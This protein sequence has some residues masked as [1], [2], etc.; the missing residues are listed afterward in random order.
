MAGYLIVN[1]SGVV[2]NNK[3]TRPVSSIGR[4]WDSY[5]GYTVISRLRVR[6]PHWAFPI[7]KSLRLNNRRVGTSSFLLFWSFDTVYGCRTCLVTA[8]FLLVLLGTHSMHL[9]GQHLLRHT[10]RPPPQNWNKVMKR[11]ENAQESSVKRPLMSAILYEL[12]AWSLPGAT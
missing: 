9:C 11:I 1:N 4:A 2:F 10:F 12:L 8:Y 6:P 3:A 5:S 7:L